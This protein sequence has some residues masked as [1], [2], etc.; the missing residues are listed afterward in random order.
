MSANQFSNGD[1]IYQRFMERQRAEGLA[2]AESS[3]ILR[4]HIPP[5]APPHFVA[6]YLC[7]GLIRDAAGEIKEANRF[8]VGV[9]FPTDYLRRA[10]PFEML[11]VFTPGV[12]HPNVSADLPMICIGRLTPNT[13]LVDILYQIYDILTYQKYN[14]REDDS[15]NPAACSW[16]RANQDRFPVDRR[17]LKRRSL[18]LEVQSL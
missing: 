16:A 11:R 10:D 15:L 1:T 3:D 17:P 6:E 8:Q 13:S 9:W 4:L 5:L 14:P 18:N 2:L 7:K 12:W